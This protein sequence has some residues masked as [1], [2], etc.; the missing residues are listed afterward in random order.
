MS[1]TPPRAAALAALA[2]A[3]A[4][5]PAVVEAP[6]LAGARG[7]ARAPFLHAPFAAAPGAGDDTTGDDTAGDDTAG[8]GS[9]GDGSAGDGSAGDGSAG[10]G[11]GT[12]AGLSLDGRALVDARGRFHALGATM[13]YAAWAYKNDRPR[14]ERN[15]A[16]L[17]GHGFDF[18][19]VLGV[20]GDPVGPD[21]W[22]GRET[23]WRWPD[24]DD[25]IAG[26][27]D[28]AYDQYGLRVQ[29]TLF[30]GSPDDGDRAALADRFAAMAAARPGKVMLFETANESYQNGFTTDEL[31]ELTIHLRDRTDVLVAASAPFDSTSCASFDAVY[32]GGVADIATVH[33]ARDNDDTGWRPVWQPWSIA[34]CT[35][36]AVS[37]NEPIGPGS[38]VNTL[39]DPEKLAASV[40]LT[41]VAGLPI[42]VFHS[43]AGVRGDVD[44]AD[45]AGAD[46]V[47]AAASLL[48]PD[49]T[50][51]ERADAGGDFDG[52]FVGAYGATDGARFADIVIGA[53]GDVAFVPTRACD[54]QVRRVTTGDVIVSASLAAGARLPLS[55]AEAF[56]VTGALR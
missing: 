28:L 13:F 47:G 31:R 21:F 19:R 44:F 1:L 2:A 43:R 52:S 22:D 38:S 23:D 33:F 12:A 26:L 3:A 32:G 54:V 45:M 40:L 5:G 53:G 42:H 8:D 25:V 14:L 16:F 51:W 46:V 48:P 37:N 10:D 29:W 18:I 7:L 20:V 50:T 15:L 55:G 6:C 39:D 11:A 24:Y 4:C 34:A 56:L 49:V 9:A 41:Y 36:G 17:A 35:G 27:T 30:G